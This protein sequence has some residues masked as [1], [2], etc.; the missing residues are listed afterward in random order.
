M[1][2]DLQARIAHA[3]TKTWESGLDFVGP[4][5]NCSRY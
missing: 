3:E 1:K 2:I 4:I 5:G